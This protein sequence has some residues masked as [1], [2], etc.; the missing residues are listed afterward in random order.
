MCVF[1]GNV[2]HKKDRRDCEIGTSK[3]RTD[4]QTKEAV[5]VR[6]MQVSFPRTSRQES[7]E[8]SPP[9]PMCKTPPLTFI[10]LLQTSPDLFL[11]FS[12]PF[13]RKCQKAKVEVTTL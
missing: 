5:V 1:Q 3:N 12:P 6:Y 10:P 9:L 13:R 8:E 2:V 7:C 11:S 4:S